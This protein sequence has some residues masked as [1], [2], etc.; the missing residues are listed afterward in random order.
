VEWFVAWFVRASLFW[1][2]VGVLLGI[3]LA[4]HPGGTLGYV[5]AHMHAN[6]LGFVSMMIFGVAYHA[7]PRFAGRPLHRRRL[8]GVHFWVANT[9]LLLLFTGFMARLTSPGAMRLVE[10]GAVVSALGTALFI[11]N[12]WRTLGPITAAAPQPSLRRA[13]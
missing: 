5:P 1:L 9:G 10:A 7:I 3:A 11:Y 6:L 13:P 8:A 2:G 4:F 12:L